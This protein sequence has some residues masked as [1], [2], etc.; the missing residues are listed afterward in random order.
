VDV[1]ANSG[2][3]TDFGWLVH[4][5]HV[6]EGVEKQVSCSPTLPD[7]KA[8]SVGVKVVSG[9]RKWIEKLERP[10]LERKSAML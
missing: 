7:H 3:Y 8:R 9:P 4:E 5:K 6:L 10:Q 1:G 2:K